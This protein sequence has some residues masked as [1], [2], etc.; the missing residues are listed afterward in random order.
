MR[1]AEQLAPRMTITGETLPPELSA[2]AQAWRAGMLDQ[3]HLRVI[4]TFVH[5]LPA[6]TPVDTVECAERFLAQQSA[7]LRPDQPEKVAN[8]CA[9]LINPDGK[10]SDVDRAR[11]RGFTWSAQRPDGM[12]NVAPLRRP[13]VRRTCVRSKADPCPEQG[14]SR[15]YWHSNSATGVSTVW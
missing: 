6:D 14:R 1:D 15:R 4:Q 11:H 9:V 12:S 8:R 2:T 10:F 3:Q 13:S 5:D 7:K